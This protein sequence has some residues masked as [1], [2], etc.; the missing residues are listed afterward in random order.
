MGV[1]GVS[2]GLEAA[3]GFLVIAVGYGT[4]W[5]LWRFVFSERNSHEDEPPAEEH[6][7]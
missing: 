3:G 4:V 2:A 5:A 1:L 6:L 7:P